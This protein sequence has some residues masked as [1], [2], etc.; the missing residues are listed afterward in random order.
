[1]LVVP[2][3]LFVGV[4]RTLLTP[5][6]SANDVVEQFHSPVHLVTPVEG[7][8]PACLDQGTVIAGTG[9]RRMVAVDSGSSSA[10]GLV[11]EGRACL[12]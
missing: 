3:H 1:M 7:T 9:W 11:V 10:H 8:L 5:S 12:G 4:G 6:H 2:Y